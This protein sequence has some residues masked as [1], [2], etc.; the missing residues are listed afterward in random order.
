MKALHWTSTRKTY[1]GFGIGL[2]PVVLAINY[3][4]VAVK[5]SNTTKVFPFLE[6]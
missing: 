2:H 1:Q 4:N 5:T 6:L 3:F